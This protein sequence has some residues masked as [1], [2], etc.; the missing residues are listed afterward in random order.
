[1]NTQND[2]TYTA[3]QLQKMFEVCYQTVY[4]WV[5]AGKLKSCGTDR[6]NFNRK[7]YQQSD[8][9]EFIKQT[10]KGS[11]APSTIDVF[12][13]LRYMGLSDDILRGVRGKRLPRTNKYQNRER[14]PIE[15]PS[16]SSHKVTDRMEY[17]KQLAKIKF[18]PTPNSQ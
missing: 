6:N 5:R 9:V 16:T 7:L 1:M 12:H 2:I 14:T 11:Y 18:K 10:H 8:I 17:I 13:A 3:D 15:I 4:Y